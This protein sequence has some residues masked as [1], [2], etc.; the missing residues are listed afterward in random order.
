MRVDIPAYLE[1]TVTVINVLKAK[2][3]G[4]SADTYHVAQV[5]PAQWSRTSTS[6]SAST[7]TTHNDTVRVHLSP[8]GFRPYRDWAQ[9]TDGWTMSDGDYVINGVVA[10]VT[11]ETL[12]SVLRD[13]DS[14]RVNHIEDRRNDALSGLDGLTKW[15][16]MVFVEGV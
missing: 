3:G 2:D 5:F 16:S 4:T 12:D 11:P 10:S 13:S 1:R 6:S 8:L 9:D 14:C 7:D 15:A